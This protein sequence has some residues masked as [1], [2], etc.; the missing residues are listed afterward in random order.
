MVGYM[1][2]PAKAG[3]TRVQVQPGL[4]VHVPYLN[5][6]TSLVETIC[7]ILQCR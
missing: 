5:K 3:G 4:R 2:V 1:N 7:P 6:G